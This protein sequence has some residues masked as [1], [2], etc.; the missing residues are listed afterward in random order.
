[1]LV[2]RLQ[3]DRPRPWKMWLYPLP[4]FV[5]LVGWLFV[6]YCTGRL[7]IAIGVTTFVVGLAVFLIWSAR[8][9]EWPF[10]SAERVG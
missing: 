6:Y 9:R 3:P 5:A 7:F 2:R 10:G 8:R 4:C 1:M